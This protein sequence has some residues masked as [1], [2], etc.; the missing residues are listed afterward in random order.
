MPPKDLPQP[1][2]QETGAS[3]QS[4]RVPQEG[5]RIRPPLFIEVLGAQ[6]LRQLT[7]EELGEPADN[8]LTTP[9]GFNIGGRNESSTIRTLTALNGVPR[10]VLEHRMRS[11]MT[12]FLGEDESLSE[13]MADDNDAVLAMGLTHQQLAE[14]LSY[15]GR[16]AQYAEEQTGQAPQIMQFNGRTYEYRK[17]AGRNV[18]GLQSPFDREDYGTYN[19]LIK[20]LDDGSQIYESVLMPTLIRKYGFY[21]RQ[22]IGR[23]GPT[24][25]AELAGFIPRTEKPA[26]GMVPQPKPGKV[27]DPWTK[28]Q[29]RQEV[30]SWFQRMKLVEV[31]K[32]YG[33]ETATAADMGIFINALGK[34]LEKPLRQYRPNELEAMKR[35]GV[36]P[37]LIP[38]AF[39]GTSPYNLDFPG[40]VNRLYNGQA[41]KTRISDGMPENPTLTQLIEW[42][43]KSSGK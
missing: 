43:Q 26:E 25:I 6:A 23:V 36:N 24:E 5:E 14:F 29:E 20:C 41:E 21:G 19:E 31:A 15:F 39:K 11:G 16:A 9:E 37:N 1:I 10:V 27:R 38:F 12:T 35:L 40:I 13:V 33:V 17:I 4:G 8:V 2:P 3:S 42:R 18:M 32:S 22:E 30:R 7:P 28:R 34:T